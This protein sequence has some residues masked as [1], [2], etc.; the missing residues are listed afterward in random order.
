MIVVKLFSFKRFAECGGSA[1]TARSGSEDSS[2]GATA[3]C[4]PD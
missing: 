3:F 4:P 2:G 1:A